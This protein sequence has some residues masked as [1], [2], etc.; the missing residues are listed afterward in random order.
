[1]LDDLR[2][3]GRRAVIVT[4]EG[5]YSAREVADMLGAALAAVLPDDLRTA[6]VLA[7]GTGSRARLAS[8]PLMLAAQHAAR[9]LH[10]QAAGQ[11]YEHDLTAVTGFADASPS[12]P[13]PVSPLRSEGTR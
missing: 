1:M 5:P 13:G 10:D 3:P 2:G 11:A 7:D 8:R 9:A 6:R 4:G 12:P